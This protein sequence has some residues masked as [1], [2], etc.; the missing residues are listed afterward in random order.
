MHACLHGRS[1]HALPDLLPK[2]PADHTYISSYCNA[3]HGNNMQMSA[4]A[5]HADP[6]TTRVWPGH[7]STPQDDTPENFCCHR[8]SA[9]KPAY[10]QGT[11]PNLIQAGCQ[12]PI[13]AVHQMAH[14]HCCNPN[15]STPTNASLCHYAA[16]HSCCSLVGGA[17]TSQLMLH[18]QA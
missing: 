12:Y 9:D 6:Y 4:E 18:E 13:A 8:L 5:V 15:R 1:L 7:E 10:D 16:G 11:P 2:S 14:S 3:L 17:A